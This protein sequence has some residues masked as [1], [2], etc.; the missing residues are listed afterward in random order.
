MYQNKIAYGS[1]GFPWVPEIY[2]GK[3]K[4]NKGI[5]PV[6]EELNNKI[7]G[8]GMCLYEYSNEEIDSIIFAFKKVWSNL[9]SLR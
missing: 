7:M 3:V 4:Y 8:I 5:C 9:D 1:K 2:K 6:A